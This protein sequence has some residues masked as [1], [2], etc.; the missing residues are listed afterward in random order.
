TLVERFAG[1]HDVEEH[2]HELPSH[3]TDGAYPTPAIPRQQRFVLRTVEPPL[4]APAAGE[5]EELPPQ[6]RASAL[7][8]PGAAKDGEP[9]LA[10]LHQVHT[11]ELQRRPRRDERLR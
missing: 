8:L 5:Q 4:L 1:L 10:G 2:R 6:E 11:G 3:G 9:R 7:G